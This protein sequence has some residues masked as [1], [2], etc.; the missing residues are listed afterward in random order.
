MKIGYHASHEQF[1]PADLLEYVKLAG[2]NGFEAVMS[3]DHITPWSVRQGHSGHVWSWLGAALAQ[4]A[5][6]FGSLAIPGGWRYHPAVLAQAIATLAQ[7]FPGRL[8]WIAAGS[9]EAMNEAVTGGG[10]PGKTERNDRLLAGV[11]VMRALWAGETVT[12]AAP[13]PVDEARLWSLPPHPPLVYGCALS[14]ETARFAG[15]WADG[16]ITVRKPPDELRQLLDAFRAGG[17]IRP[18]VLQLQV[19]WAETDDEARH[20]AWHQW[21]HCALGGDV[22]AACKT[23]QQFDRATAHIRPE[24]ME[25]HILIAADPA[26][27]ARWIAE[28][29]ALGFDEIYIHN[30]GRNQE[31]FIKFFGREVLPRLNPR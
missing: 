29:A 30:A 9:G 10:W 17:G 28:Y 14:V 6:P 4:T 22:L 8:P 11:Q 25:G 31:A 1:A 19:S 20:N 3:S 7:I 2:Q 18:L 26:R 27:H 12:R 24:D 5:L 13:V 16:L 23:P 15:E 21:R